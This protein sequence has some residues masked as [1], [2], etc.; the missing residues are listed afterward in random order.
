MPIRMLKV[1]DVK[2]IE[3]REIFQHLL[4]SIES[5]AKDTLSE[6]AKEDWARYTV[7]SNLLADVIKERSQYAIL[8]HTWLDNEVTYEDWNLK[9][10]LSGLG[11][12]KLVQFCRIAAADYGVSLAWMDTICID[13]QSTSELDE[14]I[15]SMYRWYAGPSICI[16]FLANTA[17]LV[18]MLTHDRWFTRGWTL[19]EL[20]APSRFKFYD[21]YWTTLT[22]IDIL[23]DKPS[24]SMWNVKP[25]PIHNILAE[26]TGISFTEM[27]HFIPGA[28]SGDFSRR[29]TWAAKRTTTRG[30]DRAYS[31]MG[32]FSFTFPIAYGEGV[33]RAFF[34]LIEQFLHSHRNV[35]DILNWAGSTEPNPLYKFATFQSGVLSKISR[36]STNIGETYESHSSWSTSPIDICRCRYCSVSLRRYNLLTA[37]KQ[38]PD[39]MYGRPSE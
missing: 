9:R 28:Q 4:P 26:V 8:S 33:E 6:K 18:D 23:N 37:R 34:R 36:K 35:L 25:S 21:K 17:S 39:A 30:E 27:Q 1:P 11:Y 12:D 19:Q 2:L 7:R 31:L 14:S 16:I 13:K 5:L 29:M 3:R 15:R 20:L 32:M 24:R 10:N 38:S 22:L